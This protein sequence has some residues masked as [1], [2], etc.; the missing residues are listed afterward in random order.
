MKK[1]IALVGLALVIGAVFAASALACQPTLRVCAP[2]PSSTGNYYGNPPPREQK[3]TV[4]YQN[5][6][7]W[8][9]NGPSP[10]IDTF[11]GQG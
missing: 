6:G 3:A 11:C 4:P 8:T 1:V 10:A 7:T 5:P 2:N 9:A